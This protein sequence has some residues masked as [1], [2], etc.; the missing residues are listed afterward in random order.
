MRDN[1]LEQ[2]P[3]SYAFENDFEFKIN[4]DD[5]VAQATFKS[6]VFDIKPHAVIVDRIQDR[7]GPS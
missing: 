4:N 7:P 2:F 6:I 1:K 5:D 3:S